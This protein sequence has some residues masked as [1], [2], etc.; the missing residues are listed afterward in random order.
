MRTFYRGLIHLGRFLS[1]FLLFAI[2]VFW[3]FLFLQAG[4]GKLQNIE[5]VIE[6]FTGL[7][8]PLPTLNAY[9]VAL[10]ETVGGALLIIGLGS[11]LAAIPLAITMIVA[12]LT[13]HHESVV[14]F[15]DDPEVLTKQSAFGFLLAALIVFCFGPGMFS[16]DGILKRFYSRKPKEPPVVE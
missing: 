13:A 10:I 12:L 6:F 7:G 14:K 3:G 11:R 8:I 9:L 5:P 4:W 1:P 16:I 2:R 15:L